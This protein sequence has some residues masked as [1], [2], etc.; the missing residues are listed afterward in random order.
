M[1]HVSCDRRNVQAAE[2]AA[3]FGLVQGDN[4]KED[5]CKAITA[6]NVRDR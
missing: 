3:L 1:L 5:T 4:A 2:N 6:G